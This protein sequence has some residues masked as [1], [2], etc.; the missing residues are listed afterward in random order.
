M[1]IGAVG[2]LR[3][4]AIAYVSFVRRYTRSEAI[5]LATSS[6]PGARGRVMCAAPLEY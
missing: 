2:Y 1:V 4:Q 6:A 5:V 3:G